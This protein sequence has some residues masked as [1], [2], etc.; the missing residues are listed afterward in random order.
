[1]NFKGKNVLVTGGGG[2]IGGAVCREFL[3]WR[4]RVVAVDIREEALRALEKE[5]RGHVG[6]F[7][8][9]RIDITDQEQVKIKLGETMQSLAKIDV[10][11]HCVG[12][13]HGESFRT[14]DE[15]IWVRDMNINLNGIYFCTRYVLERMV[16]AKS[17]SVVITGSVNADFAVGCPSYSA[18]KAGLVNL[19]KSLAME[20]GPHQIRTNMVSPGSVATRAWNKRLEKNPDLFEEV[21]KWYP[22]GRL[23]TPEAVAKA[24]CFLASDDASCISGVNLRVD[25]GL[26]AGNARM[27]SDITQEDFT[28]K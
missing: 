19:V 3:S 28:E 13:A 14:T 8:S 7:S 24:I 17:G 21:V 22:L 1:M 16:R 27:A 6:D 11:V 2:D 25:A 9:V 4:A 5:I 15:E 12:Y 10:L 20:Y 26:T 23:A 18:A